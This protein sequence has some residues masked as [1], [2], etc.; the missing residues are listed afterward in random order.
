MKRQVRRVAGMATLGTKRAGY[1]LLGMV[2]LVLGIIGAFL[3]L[4]PT[5]IFL[6]A[7]AWCFSRSSP[8]VEAWLLNHRRFGPTLRDWREEGAIPR[9]AK[10]AA[11][12]GM[13]I[14]YGLFLLGRPGALF[15]IAAAIF[16]G[17]GAVY[18]ATR[19]DPRPKPERE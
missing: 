18:V 19:P 5:T 16:V 7:A 15:A 4:M 12:A 10:L 11:Y 14:G 17:A 3:P 2:M 8:R 1:L 6:I 9:K 13:S